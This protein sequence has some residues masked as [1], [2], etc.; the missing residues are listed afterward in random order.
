MEFNELLRYSF[1]AIILSVMLFGLMGLIIPILPG[2]V[3][4]WVAALVFGIVEGFS[5]A[6]WVFF[7][8]MTVLMLVGSVI[9]NFIM[10]ASARQKG[11]PWTTILVALVLGIVGSIVFPPFGG[12]IAALLGLFG[13]EY[14]RQ[15]DWR[16]ALDTTTGMA[17]GCG[18]AVLI[19]A[20]IGVVMIILWLIWALRF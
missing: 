8:V 19:R 16:K 4:I 18:S 3:I 9:D 20:G 7:A 12:V 1:Y 17:L 13:L 2:L 14:Y 6:G 11:A 10:G 5:S 15:R